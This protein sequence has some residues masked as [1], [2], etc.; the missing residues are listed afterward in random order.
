MTWDVKFHIKFIFLGVRVTYLQL[1]YLCLILKA[2]C[3]ILMR[4]F[5]SLASKCRPYMANCHQA[6]FNPIFPH[7]N[8]HVDPN[9]HHLIKGQM[10]NDYNS[11]KYHWNCSA[12]GE[13]GLCKAILMSHIKFWRLKCIPPV[14]DSVSLEDLLVS[15]T[16]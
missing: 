16:L 1:N 6:S 2:F 7:L 15:V 4:W 14:S 13:K 11:R 3:M 5:E 12:M 9:S 8:G 10:V